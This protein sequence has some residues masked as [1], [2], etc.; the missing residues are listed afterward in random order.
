LP[1]AETRSSSPNFPPMGQ[2]ETFITLSE[3]IFRVA[4]ATGEW[5]S[6]TKARATVLQA[7]IDGTLTIYGTPRFLHE[8]EPVPA[9][10]FS[11]PLFLPSLELLALVRNPRPTRFGDWGTG[12]DDD[13]L[14][15]RYRNLCVIE[16]QLVALLPTRRRRRANSTATV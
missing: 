13:K 8:R 1:T 15:T 9:H 3:A 12:R 5:P 2:S 6:Y 14:D 7:T 16:A 4:D 11:K 10:A